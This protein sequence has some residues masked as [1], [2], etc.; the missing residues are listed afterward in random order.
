MVLLQLI[1]KHP[2]SL[3]RTLR[4][5]LFSPPDR[6][7]MVVPKGVRVGRSCS[8]M[9]ALPPLVLIIL[10]LQVLYRM[11][12]IACLMFRSGLIMQ[13]TTRLLALR[14]KQARLPLEAP[15]RRARL[16]LAWLVMFYSLF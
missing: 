1:T 6:G 11:D 5:P 9:W 12:S 16:Q 3:V 14:L 7:S 15:R 4:V 8:I 2:D 10:L 13:G